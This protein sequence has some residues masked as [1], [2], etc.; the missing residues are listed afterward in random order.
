MNLKTKSA[1][2]NFINEINVKKPGNRNRLL[3]SHFES[4][5]TVET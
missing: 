5:L 1:F 4:L 3:N 2:H